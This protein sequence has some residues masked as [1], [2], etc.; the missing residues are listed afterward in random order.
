MNSSYDS[1]KSKGGLEQP[2]IGDIRVKW[3][4]VPNLKVNILA[5]QI[6]DKNQFTFRPWNPSDKFAESGEGST[7]DHDS[8]SSCPVACIFCF[9]VEKCFKTIFREEIDVI[10]YDSASSK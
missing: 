1:A 9:C 7:Q 8:Q 6:T 5:Q 4:I 3:E 10:R 2:Q